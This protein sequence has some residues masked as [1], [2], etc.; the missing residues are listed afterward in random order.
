MYWLNQ[1]RRLTHYYRVGHASKNVAWEFLLLFAIVL[2]PITTRSYVVNHNGLLYGGNLTVLAFLNLGLTI[3]ALRTAA[4]AGTKIDRRYL[5]M[6]S[7]N[8]VFF[9]FTFSLSLV[10]PDMAHNLW[11]AAFT[12]PLIARLIPSLR[13]APHDQA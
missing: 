13:E 10:W 12:L 4:P 9:A 6:P 2:M 5:V 3:L 8:A 11:F 1:Q 7:I